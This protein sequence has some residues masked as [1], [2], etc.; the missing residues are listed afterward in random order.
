MFKHLNIMN[1]HFHSMIDKEDVIPI[2]IELYV[3]T[4]DI[5]VVIL[6]PVKQVF[7]PFYSLRDGDTG[8]Q[9][10]A[11]QFSQPDPG[12]EKYP[13]LILTVWNSLSKKWY[14]SNRC[15]R[16]NLLKSPRRSIFLFLIE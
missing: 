2:F 14:Q 4:S 13:A 16:F 15:V 8:P 7:W 10:V 9:T 3:T 12:T 6:R 11:A 1:F 5:S